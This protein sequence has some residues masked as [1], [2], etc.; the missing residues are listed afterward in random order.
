MAGHHATKVRDSLIAS[1]M[2]ATTPVVVAAS[3]S[4]PAQTL[5]AGTLGE[6]PSL[7][8]KVEGA[9]ALVL[10]GDAFADAYALV[11]DLR[12]P[13]MASATA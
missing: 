11:G 6:L 3:V 5:V 12:A 9:P 13:R 2:A 4:L 7:A 1:G 10:L 8:A